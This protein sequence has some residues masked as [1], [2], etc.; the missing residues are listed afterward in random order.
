V[1]IDLG[2]RF[3]ELNNLRFYT[4]EFY[5]FEKIVCRCNHSVSIT[6][7]KQD[8]SN[9]TIQTPRWQRRIHAGRIENIGLVVGDE[10]PC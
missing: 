4:E 5:V 10:A 6:F 8:F 1:C 7:A 2:F 3:D 9:A